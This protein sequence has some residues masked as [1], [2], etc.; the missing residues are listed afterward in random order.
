MRVDDWKFPKVL[1]GHFS[2]PNVLLNKQTLHIVPKKKQ[3]N[4]LGATRCP[5]LLALI[6]NIL[7][8]QALGFF[9]FLRKVIKFIFTCTDLSNRD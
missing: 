5:V 3:P 1:Y 2:F 8:W 9:F 6:N 4:N 7:F